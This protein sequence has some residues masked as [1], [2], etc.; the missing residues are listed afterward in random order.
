[1]LAHPIPI[2]YHKDWMPEMQQWSGQPRNWFVMGRGMR[3][4]REMMQSQFS[5]SFCLLES[6]RLGTGTSAT[7]G[8]SRTSV[9]LIAV[10][11]DVNSAD[12]NDTRKYCPMSDQLTVTLGMSNSTKRVKFL[13]QVFVCKVKKHVMMGRSLFVHVAVNTVDLDETAVWDTESVEK[14][15]NDLV[16]Y[17]GSIG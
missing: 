10:Q 3:M 7:K 16:Q 8:G 15:Y 11:V 6:I 13:L 17:R 1:M 12:L 14:L 5:Q 2:L 9:P 4:G